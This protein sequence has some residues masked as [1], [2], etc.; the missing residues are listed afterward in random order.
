MHSC[1]NNALRTYVKMPGRYSYKTRWKTR[2]AMLI[3]LHLEP[4]LKVEKCA[5][6]TICRCG[7][8]MLSRE[9]QHKR[10]SLPPQFAPSLRHY[11]SK[12]RLR[13]WSSIAGITSFTYPTSISY[14]LPIEG[15]DLILF[16]VTFHMAFILIMEQ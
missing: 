12:A 15:R 11:D 14:N 9:C 5:G 16:S 3:F 6:L 8:G 2:R 1:L 4:G 13:L 10:C 7:V